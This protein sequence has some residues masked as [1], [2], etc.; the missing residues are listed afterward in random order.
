MKMIRNGWLLS[1]VVMAMIG[2]VVSMSSL[3]EDDG[4][5]AGKDFN[6]SKLHTTLVFRHGEQTDRRGVPNRDSI[7]CIGGN[8]D[9]LDINRI[10]TCTSTGNDEYGNPIWS[11][12]EDGQQIDLL[13]A[14]VQCQQASN[15]RPVHCK[16][17]KSCSIDVVVGE[18]ITTV[19]NHSHQQRNEEMILP[20]DVTPINQDPYYTEGH[21]SYKMMNT[22]HE[23]KTN[24]VV[25]ESANIWTKSNNGGLLKVIRESIA[26]FISFFSWASISWFIITILNLFPSWSLGVFFLLLFT[27][28]FI[29]L[30]HKIEKFCSRQ[31]PNNNSDNNATSTTP[32]PPPPYTNVYPTTLNNHDNRPSA[33][34]PDLAGNI[35]SSSSYEDNNNTNNNNS[36]Y[37]TSTER[38]D[39]T[40]KR[41][42]QHKSLNSNMN[43]DRKISNKSK[44]NKKHSVRRHVDH[45]PIHSQ[46]QS[47]VIPPFSYSSQQQ[48]SSYPSH[49]PSRNIH[50]NVAS[51]P[52]VITNIYPPA[53]I[54]VNNPTPT[55]APAPVSVHIPP[56]NFSP[57]PQRPSA[58]QTVTQT[59]VQAPVNRRIDNRSQNTKQNG[60]RRSIGNGRVTATS[61]SLAAPDD[62]D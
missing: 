25:R 34:A 9:Y 36:N 56:A 62:S 2:Y 54:Y 29:V 44:G 31:S 32:S 10:I 53:Q 33:T 52:P 30:F 26:K 16:R 35:Y 37:D 12:A 4:C 21:K 27:T 8:C 3:N 39:S 11:C 58:Q 42:Q 15:K 50:L 51:V 14:E 13:S 45:K 61:S 60:A 7:R 19:D 57:Y 59:E 46:E 47:Q 49:L 18:Y 55:P 40:R 22:K 38:N 24:N 5:I 1:L 6:W 43:S 41:T 48:T 20:I 28:L 17:I 23:K